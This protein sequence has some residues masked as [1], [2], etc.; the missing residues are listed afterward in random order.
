MP[1]AAKRRDKLFRNAGLRNVFACPQFFSGL[2]CRL[3]VQLGECF[4]QRG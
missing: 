2:Y 1:D 4:R 3:N